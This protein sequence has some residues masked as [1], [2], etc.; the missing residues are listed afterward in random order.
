MASKK[1]ARTEEPDA[2]SSSSTSNS[3]SNSSS[4]NNNS[5]SSSKA[6]TVSVEDIK[7]LPRSFGDSTTSTPTNSQRGGN[8]E[9]LVGTV[10]ETSEEAEEDGSVDDFED[11]YEQL[12]QL[13]KGGFG[14][15]YAGTRKADGLPVAIKRIRTLVKRQSMAAGGP[16]TAGE[17]A[18]VSLLDF[19][20]GKGELIL[21]MERPVPSQDLRRYRFE[22]KGPLEENLA[23]SIMKQLV[24]AAIDM[25]SKG[26]FHRDIKLSNLLMETG[27]AQPRVRVIDFGC[28][29]ILSRK[30]YSTFSGTRAYAPPEYFTKLK[31][32]A[33]PTTVWQLGS[34]LY[35]ILDGARNF[36]TLE[37]C[38]VGVSVGSRLPRLPASMLDDKPR[39][40]GH[41]GAAPPASLAHVILDLRHSELLPSSFTPPHLHQLLQPQL[42]SKDEDVRGWTAALPTIPAPRRR[43]EEDEQGGGTEERA[44]HRRREGR[45]TGR[46]EE[47]E[48]PLSARAS[49]GRNGLRRD[50][51]LSTIPTRTPGRRAMN[52]GRV[53][54]QL[55]KKKK[56]K[57]KKKKKK[58][59]RR[60]GQESESESEGTGGRGDGERRKRRGIESSRKAAPQSLR[61][62]R[63]KER[64]RMR[65]GGEAS[66]GS[67]QLTAAAAPQRAA[68]GPGPCAAFNIQTPEALDFSKPQ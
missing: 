57:K 6:N 55:V 16:E 61:G 41:S 60:V 47:Q 56:N 10:Q 49:R 63:K 22:N 54:Q 50:A 17:S 25:H 58:K 53:L 18:A 29:C 67:Q 28:G 35:E 13:G 1:R 51:A 26:I 65:H 33:G 46:Y 40:A 38:C 48:R 68:A 44:Q 4:R 9:G 64:D 52:R 32:W 5:S 12:Q 19:Y 36:N 45:S 23:K 34:V 3:S 59:N 39:E 8:D 15:V 43:R 21:V 2:S 42:D 14:C 37:F 7:V 24:D 62:L 30:P 66:G 31:Y 20:D 27:S 11:K